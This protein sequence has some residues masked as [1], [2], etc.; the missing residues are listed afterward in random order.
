MNEEPEVEAEDD[1]EAHVRK[2]HSARMD[3]TR[4]H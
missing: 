3:N 1:V 4:H 2:A